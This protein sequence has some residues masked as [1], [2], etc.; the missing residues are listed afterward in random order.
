MKIKVIYKRLHLAGPSL[1]WRAWL[2]A[3]A[4]LLAWILIQPGA[5]IFTDIATNPDD[6]T[7]DRNYSTSSNQQNSGA[8]VVTVSQSGDNLTATTTAT[9]LPTDPVWQ[10]SLQSTDPTCSSVTSGWNN[11]SQ[12]KYIAF[13]Q[14]YCFRVTNTS[15]DTGYAEIK[16]TIPDPGLIVRQTQTSIAAMA[17]SVHSLGLDASDE[18]GY[19]VSLD[20]DRLAVGAYGDDGTSNGTTNG[21]AVYIFKR[22]GSTWSLERKIEDGSDGFNSL[23]AGDFFGYSVSL[24]GDRLA[25]GSRY[26]DGSANS[27]GNSGAVYIFKRTATTW[28]L[29]RKIEAGVN[30]LTSLDTSDEFGY[31]VSLNGDRLAAGA[32]YDYGF[33]NG[34]TDAGA[35]YIFKRTGTTWSLERKIE[36]GSDGFNYLD[37]GDF[38][39]YSVSLD[40]DRLAA[41]AYS[42]D[43]SGNGT[44]GAGAVYIFK[45]TATTWALERKI[46][47]GSGGFNDLDADDL[48]GYSVALDGIRLAVGAYSDDGSGNGTT[49]AGAVY[50]FKRT[51][52]TWALERKIEDGTGGFN[53]LDAF[54]NFGYSIS[55]DGDRLAVGAYYDDGSGNGTSNAGAVYIF[56]RTAT[57]WSLER[58][59]EAG[60]GGFHHP[61]VNDYFGHNVSIDGARLAAGAY[62]DD[63]SSDSHSNAGSVYIFKRTGSTWS[64]TNKFHANA[65]ISSDS[66]QN[67]KTTNANEPSCDSNGSFGDAGAGANLIAISASDA[68]KWACFRVN[69]AADTYTYI[70]KQIIYGP[71]SLSLTQDST[72]VTASG[73][74]LSEFSFFDSGPTNPTCSSSNTTA[75]WTTGSS[76]TG[77]DDNDWVCFRAKN[78]IEIY[79]YAKVQV[80]LTTPVISLSQD[81]DSVDAAATMAGVPTIDS[82]SWAHTTPSSSNP[83][84]SSASYNPAGSSENSVSITNPTDNNKY[85]CFKVLNSVNV[86]AYRKLRIDFNRPAITVTRSGSTLTAASSASDLPATP[87]WHHTA[88]LSSRPTCSEAV[89]SNSGNTVAG[90]SHGQHYCFRVTDKAGNHGYGQIQVDLSAPQP[91]PISIPAQAPNLSLSQ[92]NTTVT[93]SG[94]GLS[95]FAFFVAAGPPACNSTNTTA[96]WTAGSSA[97]GLDDNDWVCFRAQNRFGVYGFAKVQVDLTAAVISLTQD[98]KSVVGT[99]TMAG[100]T[101]IDGTSW[102]HSTPSSTNPT[103]SSASYNSAG[104]SENSVGITAADNNKYVCFKVLNSLKVPAYEKLRIDFNPPVVTVTQAGVTLTAATNATDL[105]TKPIWDQTEPLNPAPTCSKAKY[106]R[107]GNAVDSASDGQHYCF[108]VADKAGNHGYGS[109]LV[110]LSRPNLSLVQSNAT[111]T[112]SGSSLSA[113]AFFDNGQTDPDCS[114]ANTTAT[115]TNGAAASGLDDDDWVCFRARNRVGIYGYANLRVDLTPPSLSLE[116]DNQIVRAN[117]V[118]LSNYQ[119]A[120]ATRAGNCSRQIS[121]WT[122]SYKTSR[123]TSGTWVCF[124]AKNDLD[125]W[126]YR[127]TTIPQTSSSA[128]TLTPPPPVTAKPAAKLPIVTR[129]A[130]TKQSDPAQAPTETSNKQA[131]LQTSLQPIALLALFSL[132]IYC[133]IRILPRR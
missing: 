118:N 96:I 36:D 67:F 99:A 62:Y 102:A 28:S 106:N 130:A 27:K 68:N 126:G 78:S 100:A 53:P 58:K 81:Q 48:F 21:G 15:N 54:D 39:G 61:G 43:G 14:Y 37:A 123:L 115:W 87:V 131:T 46:E 20:G 6:N 92:N 86:P 41:G 72:T 24:N 122:N 132:A 114:A 79:G 71:P 25:V 104:S 3:L 88:A 121:S 40:G 125:V 51:G 80:D 33:G 44:S 31:S 16:T 65:G 74:N 77:L 18:L 75:T 85:V 70:K 8:P 98:Q 30:N 89:Y 93:V 128:A 10:Y 119:Y 127:A 69:N 112:A 42:D 94:S 22:T 49:N 105:P 113:F 17:T 47:D 133:V 1:W 97:I 82:S 2:I 50:I 34:T 52:S 56:K 4:F 66:W 129:P 7:D 45:R 11:G 108:R 55:L 91:K 84:C 73:D 5:N 26:D 23:D 59:V 76:A 32:I 57:T 101:T 60:S 109:I 38:F 95:G 13:N 63:G 29:E 120:T 83:T 12:V 90:V 19:S 117:G 103:C 35:V 110:D 9:D 107:R 111:V 116:Q 64:D 124:R